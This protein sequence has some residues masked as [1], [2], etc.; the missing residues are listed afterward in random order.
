MNMDND[1]ESRCL[2]DLGRGSHEAF[3]TLF[4]QYHPRLKNFLFGFIKNEDEALDMAQDIFFKIWVNRKTIAE[5]ASFKAYLFKMARNM[6]YDYNE[7]T[8][9][10]ESYSSKQKDA[11][12]YSDIIEEEIYAKEL[13]LLIDIAIEHMPEQRQRIFK[14]SRKEGLSNDEIAQRLDL[15]KRS[16]ENHIT[17]ALADLRRLMQHTLLLFFV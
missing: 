16:V 17:Q 3:D 14:M 5:V 10:K 6:V 4:M 12:L 8:L 1:L 7:H 11:P 15:N 9:V 2:K 13:S